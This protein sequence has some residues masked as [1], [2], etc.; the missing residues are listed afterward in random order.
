MKTSNTDLLYW[1][2]KPS[3]L[4]RK[5]LIFLAAVLLAVGVLGY[6]IYGKAFTPNTPA[7]LT[8]NI[9]LI[10]TGATL[11]D[12]VDSLKAHGQILHE[13]RF[14]WT[15]GKMNYTGSSIRRGRYA[16]PSLASSKALISIL[17]GGKQT[18]VSLT[19]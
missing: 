10:P 14:R 6:I 18:P 5:L 19:I 11:D 12:V 8:D 4:K 7:V 2:F 1:K 16:I 3:P 15:A 9:L 17:R 13:K